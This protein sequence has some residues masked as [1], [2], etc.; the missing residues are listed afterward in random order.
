MPQASNSSRWFCNHFCQRPPSY[1]Q[2]ERT[3]RVHGPNTAKDGR[4]HEVTEL[5]AA[6]PTCDGLNQTAKRFHTIAQGFRRELVERRIPWV[7]ET[8]RLVTLKALHIPTPPLFPWSSPAA[9]NP[10]RKR[11]GKGDSHLSGDPSH[12]SDSRHRPLG[13]VARVIQ[14]A[15][16]SV[17]Q[18]FLCLTHVWRPQPTAIKTFLTGS[19]RSTGSFPSIL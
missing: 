7:M 3:S 5:S 16:I 6:Y 4:R 11:D 2:L 8:K 14:S 12:S 13:S 17:D 9:S 1:C 10:G 15:F 19:T 18:R